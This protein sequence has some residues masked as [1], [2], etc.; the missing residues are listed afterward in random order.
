MIPAHQRL[1]H[2]MAWG[3]MGVWNG[4]STTNDQNTVVCRA[5]CRMLWTV[6]H[7]QT[8]ASSS[9]SSISP[10][11]RQRAAVGRGQWNNKFRY[12]HCK[13]LALH[14]TAPKAKMKTSIWAVSRQ[15]MGTHSTRLDSNRQQL[16]PTTT[17][18]RTPDSDCK[19]HYQSYA[20]YARSF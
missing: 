17:T 20:L 4:D 3:S 19:T 11:S 13:F 10:A 5:V 14:A 8:A 1:C 16:Q 2:G 18:S 7:G 15:R 12:K 6:R 9:S